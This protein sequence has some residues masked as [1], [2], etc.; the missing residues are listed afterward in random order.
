MFNFQKAIEDAKKDLNNKSLQALV[1]GPSGA[2]K[3]TLLG[4]FG[5]KTL[6]LYTSGENH[7]VVATT[8]YGKDN[9]VAVCI[10]REGQER[11]APEA[12]YARLLDILSNGDALV[13]MG[14]KAIAIDGATE[15]EEIIKNTKAWK[16]FCTTDKGKHNG[17]AEKDATLRGFRPIIE[18]LK[19]LNLDHG[20][21]YAMTCILDVKEMG[22]TGE[23]LESTPRL[24][25]YGVAEG[26][27]QQFP[28]YF[29]VG[30]MSKGDKVAHRVQF[31]AGV[32]KESKDQ[33]GRV[34]K[35]LN[36]YP[37]LT[38]VS[39]LPNTFEANLGKLAEFKRGEG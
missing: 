6:Y 28:D 36:F 19:Q 34:K 38:G 37:R 30:R 9:V 2:G 5:V 18:R 33:S 24:S 31:L 8:T 14:V 32:S 25:G 10:D 11:L 22:E 16:E 1:L 26:L 3:S 35:T 27:V 4:T 20:I 13:K 23:I 17:F 12:A 21:M 15:I 29:V 7:G 39:E